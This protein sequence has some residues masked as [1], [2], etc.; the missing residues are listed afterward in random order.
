MRHPDL[1]WRFLLMVLI[2]HLHQPFIDNIMS[3]LLYLNN[4][5]SIFNICLYMAALC[6]YNNNNQKRHEENFIIPFYGSSS[7]G[8]H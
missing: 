3:I 1:G 6:M 7:Y 2:V 4:N 8:K 5:R